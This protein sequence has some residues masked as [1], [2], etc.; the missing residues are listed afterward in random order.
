M[1]DVGSD[2]ALVPDCDLGRHLAALR[3]HGQRLK[4]V[5]SVALELNHPG[6]CRELVVSPHPYWR[7]LGA[8]CLALSG[9]DPAAVLRLALSDPSRDVRRAAS[10]LLARCNG[11]PGP[12]LLQFASSCGDSECLSAFSQQLLRTWPA[13]ADGRALVS[14][15]LQRGTAAATRAGAKLL[16]RC[17]ASADTVAAAADIPPA[18][19]INRALALNAPGMLLSY[20]TAKL[21]ARGGASPF[22][23][24]LVSHGTTFSP[25]AGFLS[26]A[27]RFPLHITHSNPRFPPPF[28][29]SPGGRRRRRDSSPLAIPREGAEIPPG[30]GKPRRRPR[31]GVSLRPDRR[32]EERGLHAAA[33]GAPGAAPDGLGVRLCRDGRER[34]ERLRGPDGG[35]AAHVDVARG[36]RLRVAVA[37]RQP[38]APGV[39][40]AVPGVRCGARGRC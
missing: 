28:T 21:K 19:M 34:E 5:A 37:R 6:Q 24:R 4:H 2:E 13:A 22:L 18:D 1:P 3:A 15:L 35:G 7:K 11:T 30:G 36:A 26:A 14:A 16:F 20:F 33:A 25:P 23:P 29:G 12:V 27:S 10:R 9:A 32:G 8:L 31:S 39:P 17:G 40:P 38:R